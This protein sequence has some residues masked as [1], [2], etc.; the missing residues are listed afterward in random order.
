MTSSE[1]GSWNCKPTRLRWCRGSIKWVRLTP[2]V[3]MSRARAIYGVPPTNLLRYTSNG[4]RFRLRLSLIAISSP[5]KCRS[6]AATGRK[7][8]LARCSGSVGAPVDR[9]RKCPRSHGEERPPT[10]VAPAYIRTPSGPRRDDG[11]RQDGGDGRARDVGG[12]RASADA[13]DGRR[14]GALRA[15]VHAGPAAQG[16]LLSHQGGARADQEGAER[17]DLWNEG[18]GRRRHLR[19]EDQPDR[20]GASAEGGGGPETEGRR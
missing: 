20:A 2:S 12:R 14:Q 1:S 4:A 3:L 5:G 6:P 9:S 15:R 17:R 16:R 11:D 7:R 13:E 8:P 10:R 19:P 18:P